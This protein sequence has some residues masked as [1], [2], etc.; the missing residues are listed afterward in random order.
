MKPPRAN[1]FRKHAA[2]VR[3]CFRA[4]L[5]ICA[6]SVRV[7]RS[8]RN[9][10]LRSCA[11]FMVRTIANVATR[12][13]SKNLSFFLLHFVLH[14]ATMYDSMTERTQPARDQL[15]IRVLPRIKAAAQEAAR[16]VGR[17]RSWV[18]EQALIQLLADR[19]PPEVRDMA[20]QWP[21]EDDKE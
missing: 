12:V 9:T 3:S 2:T 7:T 4:A 11:F 8:F 17:S 1:I 14:R 13:H 19:L 20:S 6:Y 15:S 21:A 5:V 10:V 18:V 16:N